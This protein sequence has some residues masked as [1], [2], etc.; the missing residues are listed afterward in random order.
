MSTIRKLR[1]EEFKQWVEIS[2]NAYPAFRV[3]NP[4]DKQKME[5][6]LIYLQNNEPTMNFY[7]VFREEEL[8]GGM[9]IHDYV[10][11]MFNIMVRS[12]GLGSVAVQ[13][14]HKK[15]KVAK[16][17]VEY[18]LRYSIANKSPIAMLYPFRPDFYKKMGFGF[19]TKMNHYKIKPEN[20]PKGYTKKSLKFFDAADKAQVIECCNRVMKKTHG[21]IEM[22]EY[23]LDGFMKRPENNMICSKADGRI[24]G[25]MIYSFER[26][27]SV[28]M[29]TNDIVVKQLVHE[30]IETLMEFYTFLNSQLD[31]IDRIVFN[32]Q[33]EDFHHMLLDPRDRSDNMFTP[34]Y[35]QTNL[36]GIGIM[37]RVVDVK[38]LFRA[39]N[40]HN[41]NNQQCTI[42]INVHDSF[43][44][45]NEGGTVVS[46]KN[47]I[48]YVLDEDDD[49][50]VEISMDIA[51]FSSMIIGAVSFKSLIGYGLAEI[52]NTNYI[53]IVSKIFRV[54]EKPVCLTLF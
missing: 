48:P 40:T 53:D 45:E 12:T 17:I 27:G 46:F 51:D 28:N 10:L 35:H 52:S 29:L 34:V 25:Y 42:R 47:G 44:P 16:D 33:D 23:D 18:F 3:T 41:F 32:T 22:T 39:L 30:D 37:Y 43:L 19:G 50:E 21:M 1:D 13:L 15:E 11:N 6:R 49:Y 38:E 54:D 24:K 36:Q 7:G 4:D 2:G 9:R 8:V 20:L 26:A 31:Q 14:L 5:E